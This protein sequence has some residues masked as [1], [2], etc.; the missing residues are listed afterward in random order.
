MSRENEYVLVPAVQVTDFFPPLCYNGQEYQ[1]RTYSQWSP[2]LA[3]SRPKLI[4]DRV[5]SVT[6]GEIFVLRIEC[7]IF[8]IRFAAHLSMSLI[9]VSLAEVE[10]VNSISE[11]TNGGLRRHNLRR[12]NKYQR[13]NLIRV[14]T[15]VC[16][17]RW[18]ARK[19]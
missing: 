1:G 2:I 11:A 13:R 8:N 10:L 5:I 15:D 18:I 17:V 4:Q 7:S 6:P 9:S 12:Q 19:G 14:A 3:E 16:L